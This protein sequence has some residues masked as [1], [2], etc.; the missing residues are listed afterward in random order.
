MLFFDC[1]MV[2]IRLRMIFPK[3]LPKTGS[4]LVGLYDEGFSG[5][6][7]GLSTVTITDAFQ[8]VGK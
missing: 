2:V 4:K 7:P 3:I 5:G 1:A 8:V 6:L